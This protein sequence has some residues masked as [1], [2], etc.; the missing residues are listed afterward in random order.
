MLVNAEIVAVYFCGP[1]PDELAMEV[2]EEAG[3]RLHPMEGPE[4]VL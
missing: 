4:G 2:F 1:Y 3:T